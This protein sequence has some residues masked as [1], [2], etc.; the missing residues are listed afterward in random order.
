M[1]ISNFLEENNLLNTL[2]SFKTE[3]FEKEKIELNDT[4]IKSKRPFLE[5]WW[6]VYFPVLSKN[7]FDKFKSSHSSSTEPALDEFNPNLNFI[8]NKDT[9]PLFMM[10]KT[11][12]QKEKDFEDIIEVDDDLHSNIFSNQVSLSRMIEGN[13]FD[14]LFNSMCR[15]NEEL[16]TLLNDL[17]NT[18]YSRELMMIQ[19]AFNKKNEKKEEEA[20][21]KHSNIFSV[22]P[23]SESVQ[24][25]INTIVKK[26]LFSIIE[27]N[28]TK[29]KTDSS[30]LLQNKR[31]F[32]EE[33]A[34][35]KRSIK[36]NKIVYGNKHLKSAFEEI[37][38]KNTS[39]VSADKQTRPLCQETKSNFP[40]DLNYDTNKEEDPN[41]FFSG[42]EDDKY[43][44][45][46][47]SRYR[48]VS[49]NGNQWQVLIM[50]NKKKRYV[51]SYSMEEE[52]AKAY[53]K[54]ALQNHGPKAKTNYDYTDEE[55]K[56]ILAQP[57]ILR[58]DRLKRGTLIIN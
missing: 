40:N 44:N 10:S 15:G 2:N 29:S 25:T 18:G 11:D 8:I 13:N 19:E 31:P 54:A 22:I 47:G 21:I 3:A 32:S 57:P 38:N 50:V 5:E 20:L 56:E 30:C 43:K 26:Q 28:P 55:L 1:F 23:K 14:S 58:L 12:I 34:E 49:R 24:S 7:A 17:K 45:R 6:D 9:R 52:A 46:R 16:I 41:L 33:P 37:L 35:E 36:N 39:G 53:D 42:D 51:G 48:G 27:T 4:A